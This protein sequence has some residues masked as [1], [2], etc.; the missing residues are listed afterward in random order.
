M[1]SLEVFENQTQKY[2][3]SVIPENIKSVFSIEAGATAGWYRYVGK[4][5]KCFGVDGFGTSAKPNDVYARFGLIADSIAKE[6][7]TIIKQNKEI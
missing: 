6:I 4:Y 3:N 7:I 2:K 1:P 5:G